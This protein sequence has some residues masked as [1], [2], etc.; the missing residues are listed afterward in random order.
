ME[1][2]IKRQYGLVVTSLAPMQAGV[3]GWTYLVE[4]TAGKYVLKGVDAN[5]N[6]IANEP[7]VALFLKQQGLPIAQYVPTNENRYLWHDGSNVYHMQRFVEGEMLAFHSASD[8]FMTQ[9]AQLLGK[10][11]GHLCGFRQLPIGMGSGFID[12][13]Q[14]GNVEAS[15]QRTLQRAQAKEDTHTFKD[16]EYRLSQVHRL[17]STSFDLSRLTCCNTHGDYKI[18]QL[19]CGNDDILAIID[20]TGTCVHPVCW[21]I[22]RSY[23][24]AAPSC[25]NG[26]IDIDTF[27]AYVTEYLRFY[28]LNDYDAQMMP[29]FLWHQL[30]ACDYYGQYYDSKAANRE[31]F[32]FQAQFATKLIRWFEKNAGILS[33]RLRA[34]I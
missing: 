34:I 7:E 3:G 6:Y 26:E 16:V 31:D 2:E 21:E 11:H 14:S 8:W 19:I 23:T 33:E 20:W 24:Y 13:M 5:D 15:Y 28:P 1:Q 29:Y 22:I 9:S 18:S 4:T 12:Y 25:K 17:R 30:L 27:L 32:L 10:I